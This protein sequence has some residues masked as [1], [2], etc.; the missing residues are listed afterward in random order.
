MSFTIDPSGTPIVL[1]NPDFGD[2]I[3]KDPNDIRRLTRG[4]DVRLLVMSDYPTLTI[5][6][7][8]FSRIKHDLMETVRAF[9]IANAGLEITIEDH[10]NDTYD[11]YIISPINE[12]V[13]VRP[14]CSYDL[15]FEFLVKPV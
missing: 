14:D 9:L 8:Q 3:R 7:Y 13:A 4:F 10:L 12:I 2:Q 5:F 1:R 6:I 15:G 11:G